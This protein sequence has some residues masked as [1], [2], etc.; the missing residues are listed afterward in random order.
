[1]PFED[2]DEPVE[3]PIEDDLEPG[4]D[5]YF[6]DE[7]ER[8][9]APR[10]PPVACQTTEAFKQ[11]HRAQGTTGEQ[12]CEKVRDI[13][14]YMEKQQMNTALFL[15]HLL[16]NTAEV[17]S[18]T[19]C[20][21][22]RTSLTH[23]AELPGV[24]RNL[25]RPPRKHGR[26]YR[27]KGAAHAMTEVA[28][29]IIAREVNN[30]MRA[31][32][33]IMEAQPEDFNEESLLKITLDEMIPQV[34]AAAPTWWSICNTAAFTPKQAARNTKKSSPDTAILMVT[35]IV[36]FS[37]SVHRCKLQQLCSAYLKAC[38]LKSRAFDTLH[39]L[40]F[41][42]S[43][44]TVYNALDRIAESAQAQMREDVKQ[45][46][47]R[48]T[49]D[50]INIRF[51]SYEQR[52]D[53]KTHFDSG[54][55]ATVYPVKDPNAVAPS[56][57]A[58]QAKRAAGAKDPISPFTVI[59][60]EDK[61]SPQIHS[62]AVHQI[63]RFLIDSEP[64]D[65]RTYKFKDSGLF[66]PPPPVLQLP[67]GP[68]HALVQYMCGTIHQEEA[69]YEG[70]EKCIREWMR[71]LGLSAPEDMQKMSEEQLI[72]W[73]GDQLTAS[74]MR[75]IKR[76]RAQDLN[77]VQRF[78]WLIEQPGFFHYMIN[79]GF[80]F[81]HQ[82][83]GVPGS[84]GLKHAIDVLDRKNLA[85]PSVQGTFHHNL[86]ELL[87]HVA[88]AHF[89]DAACALAGVDSLQD[90]RERSP[91]ALT[92]LAN[93]IWTKLA[94]TQALEELRS[95][96]ARD[97]VH[98]QS[99]MFNRDILDYL[100]LDDAI[101]HGDVGRVRNLLPRLLFR[102]IGGGHSNYVTE[103]LELIQ[104]LECEWPD[105][106]KVWIL[107]YCWLGNTTGRAG[108]FAPFDLIQ[109]HNIRD[110]K[111][112]FAVFGPYATWKYIKKISAAIPTMRKIKD[113]V[114]ADINHF[115][116][117]KSHTKPAKEADVAKLQRVYAT[118]K[119]HIYDQK[120]T[121]LSK[122]GKAK[123]YMENGS[124]FDTL[125]TT[126][127]KWLARH[128]STRAETQD[129]TD[130][131]MLAAMSNVAGGTGRADDQH[132]SSPS[133]SPTTGSNMNDDTGDIADL[134]MASVSSD[135]SSLSYE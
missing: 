30:E 90:L 105:D 97:E 128:V 129:W 116:R 28:K 31:L 58:Y 48:G 103:T 29:E 19:K 2:S 63:L 134:E 46:P 83:Y 81:H 25:Y 9:Y 86:D 3:S 35:A 8:D 43:Q 59:D 72:V 61:A 84:M 89:R 55:A 75:G 22:E 131:A 101:R 135:S 79:L 104:A 41:C 127:K 109:E 6:D 73:I 57:T 115:R 117:G 5:E 32:R 56:P 121:P 87:H 15:H 11:F 106:L 52:T 120:R 82:Y 99:V 102:F 53:N 80:S 13:I 27:A 64:F 47:V 95:K 54:T 40:Y 51:Q 26:G 4:D 78:D 100:D 14:E 45:Y 65:L 85:K 107:Q 88:E 21:Y 98:E 92:E 96:K 74:R 12:F 68:E 114:E 122:E 39:A 77:S 71:Q 108:C 132:L 23:S 24:L 67:T 112:I 113:H 33:P 38:G 123:D 133:S 36:C 125:Q 94:S 110:I 37:R 60:L 70:N 111:H 124:N 76:F 17:I 118:G 20:Q 16:W 126:M 93:E 91:E 130:Y 34:K 119:I 50:N 62:R 69:S 49:H 42:M 7:D 66:E 44:K 18:D 10:Q 1:M